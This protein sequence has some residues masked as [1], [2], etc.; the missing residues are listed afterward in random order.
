MTGNS[1]LN[2]GRTSPMLAAAFA[3]ETTWNDP[4]E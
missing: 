4:P 3:T 2:P 1:F